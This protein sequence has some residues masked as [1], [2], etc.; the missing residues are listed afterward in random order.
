MTTQ[1]KSRKKNYNLRKELKERIEN[2]ENVCLYR[3]EIINKEDRP[4]KQT[5]TET[6]KNKEAEQEPESETEK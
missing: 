3:G 1:K 6:E 4:K 2:G 5:E